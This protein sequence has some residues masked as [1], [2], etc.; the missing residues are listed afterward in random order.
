MATCYYPAIIEKGSSGFGI[1]FPDF[2]GCTS[3]GNTLQ[4]AALKAE[5]ALTGHVVL[6]E[7][8]RDPIPDPTPLDQVPVDPEVAEAARVLVRAELAGRSVRVNI[9]LGERVLSRVDAAAKELGMSRSGFL[10]EAARRMLQENL[11]LPT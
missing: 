4:E 10:C 8:D 1:T 11:P 6:M 3:F 7:Q 2:P 9:T 5:E